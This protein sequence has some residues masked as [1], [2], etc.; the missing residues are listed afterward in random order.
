MIP[1]SLALVG[2]QVVDGR[3]AAAVPCGCVLVQEDRI[4]AVG[5]LNSVCIPEGTC[6][7]NWEII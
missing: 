3:G 2:G 6:R 5:P 7:I 1:Q 4:A